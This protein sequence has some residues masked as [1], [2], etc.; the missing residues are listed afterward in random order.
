M[1]SGLC[2]RHYVSNLYGRS[3]TCRYCTPMTGFN[4]DYPPEMVRQM[5]SIH[6]FVSPNPYWD[7][8]TSG[9]HGVLS[10]VR[11]W[12]RLIRGKP[13]PNCQRREDHTCCGEGYLL[14]LCYL[15]GVSSTGA[16][17]RSSRFC[18]SRRRRASS[19]R[20]AHICSQLPTRVR[21]W[22]CS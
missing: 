7:D 3:T 13:C 22:R 15:T 6:G 10:T 11:F 1:F 21:R 18:A 17:R 2:P 12:M 5:I 14:Q 8:Q 9:L 19:C 16:G 4:K 20:R